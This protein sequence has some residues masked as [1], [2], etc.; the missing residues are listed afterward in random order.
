[1]KMA[2][3]SF[4]FK[5]RAPKLKISLRVLKI[6]NITAMLRVTSPRT[7]PWEDDQKTRKFGKVINYLRS[8]CMEV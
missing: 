1:M 2:R 8:A 3:K 7:T 5:G 4:L 6:D